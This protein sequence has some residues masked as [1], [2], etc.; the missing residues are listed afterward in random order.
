MAR[1]NTSCS[2]FLN[3]RGM[4]GYYSAGLYEQVTEAI[5]G[6]GWSGL[7]SNNYP[8]SEGY[9][10]WKESLKGIPAIVKFSIRPLSDLVS[11]E[12]KSGLEDAINEYRRD[13][14]MTFPVTERSCSRP[15]HYSDCCPK[16]LGKGWLR[17]TIFRGWDL[18][19]DV[20]S[21]T[22][23]YY[24]VISHSQKFYRTQSIESDNPRWDEE[25]DLGSVDIG[26]ELK[27]E[28]KDDNPFRQELLLSCSWIVKV[29]SYTL[30]CSGSSS[31]F[32][33]KYT[34]Y[35]GPHLTGDNC[36]IYEPF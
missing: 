36:D 6:N 13:K 24:I 34:L 9:R 20:F 15:T 17:V 28:L 18:I 5:G 3:N 23:G 27:L 26:Q 19:G 2:C 16:Q 21:V 30:T 1:L 25:Y 7:V 8:D 22:N 32:K 12:A 14:D 31:T 29:G 33:A 10:R 4:R 11:D 35:C